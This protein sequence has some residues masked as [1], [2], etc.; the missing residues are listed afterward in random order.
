M[1]A[2]DLLVIRSSRFPL[3]IR[4]PLRNYHKG[5]RHA[6]MTTTSNDKHPHQ[7]GTVNSRTTPPMQKPAKHSPKKRANA[8]TPLSLLPSILPPLP[9]QDVNSQSSHRTHVLVQET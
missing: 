8:C 1:K 5:S 9:K 3:N 2:F 4:S 7:A 6:I